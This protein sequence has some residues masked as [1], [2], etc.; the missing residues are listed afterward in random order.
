MSKFKVGDKVTIKPSV[1]KWYLSHDGISCHTKGL[2]PL[3]PDQ[4][5]RLDNMIVAMWALCAEPNLVGEVLRVHYPG[6]S[7]ENYRVLI[8]G[9]ETNIDKRNLKKVEL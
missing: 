5:R 9:Y 1:V 8:A 7:I 3:D 4:Q 2:L 6:S